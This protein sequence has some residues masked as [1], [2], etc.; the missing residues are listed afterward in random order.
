M[1]GH[2]GLNIYPSCIPMKRVHRIM[3]TA[4]MLRGFDS[5]GQNIK[6][7]QACF[8]E[9]EGNAAGYSCLATKSVEGIPLQIPS[10][11]TSRLVFHGHRI[12]Q[13]CPLVIVCHYSDSS[14]IIDCTKDNLAGARRA[15]GPNK[16]KV[17]AFVP[18]GPGSVTDF[19]GKGLDPGIGYVGHVGMF[20]IC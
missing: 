12:Y 16:E 5:F 4:M 18:G 14:A 20:L 15:Y 2:C 6:P 17:Q 10:F 1:S 7:E 9:N 13:G 11:T 3:A 19:R 8:T